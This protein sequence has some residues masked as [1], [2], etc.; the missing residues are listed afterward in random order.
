MP[1]IPSIHLYAA[2]LLC[3]CAGG[4]YGW[5]ALVPVIETAFNGSTAQAGRVFSLAIVSFTLAVLTIGRLSAI[6]RSLFGTAMIGIVGALFL[7]LASF[8]QHYWLFLG[9]FSAGFG[10]VSG[11]LYINVLSM[12]A[13]SARS[14]W[15]TPLMVAVFG[16]GGVVFGP[17]WRQLVAHDWGM[18]ALLPLAGLMLISSI[19]ALYVDQRLMPTKLDTTGVSRRSSRSDNASQS[20]PQQSGDTFRLA[21][22]WGIFATGSTAG[23]MVLGLASKII[24]HAGGSV[25]VASTGIAGVAFGNTI[26]RLSVGAQLFF[27]HSTRIALLAT[28][29]VASGLLLVLSSAGTA[30]TVIGLSLVAFGYGIMASVVP[31]IVQHQFGSSN[32][33]RYYSITFTA[34]GLAGLVSPWLAGVL[35]DISGNFSSAIQLALLIT[36]CCSVLLIGFAMTDKVD[37]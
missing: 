36:V 10:F 2:A 34:W 24:E 19:A 6:V 4:L 3:F 26:G 37:R 17:L 29:V 21:L 23:L 11:A 22:I 25:S 15:L 1:V 5:S 31:V 7:L 28:I 9:F 16:L 20:L 13:A 12:A 32:F 8:A 33:S 18:H 30:M 27:L 35:Y 14:R